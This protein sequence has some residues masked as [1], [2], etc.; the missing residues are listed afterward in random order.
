M[1]L[2]II[3]ADLNLLYK[4]FN[5]RKPSLHQLYLITRG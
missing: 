1:Y 2:Y 5:L 3:Y 4:P